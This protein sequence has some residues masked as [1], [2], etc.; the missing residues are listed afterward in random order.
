MVLE[1]KVYFLFLDYIMFVYLIDIVNSILQILCLHILF[2]FSS[3]TWFFQ[4]KESVIT[5]P[6]LLCSCLFFV[7]NTQVVASLCLTLSLSHKLKSL[8]VW[9]GEENTEEESN[10]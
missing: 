6:Q 7:Q 5:F 1:K 2:L 9:S 3:F 4:T 10:S 8:N